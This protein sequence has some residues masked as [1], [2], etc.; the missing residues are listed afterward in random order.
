MKK[1]IVLGLL[2][3]FVGLVGFAFQVFGGPG[4]LIKDGLQATDVL[5]NRLR[6]GIFPQ[7]LISS[8]TI[9]GETLFGT[10]FQNTAA[11]SEVTATM[12]SMEAGVSPAM[13]VFQL[14]K[15]QYPISVKFFSGDKIDGL[16]TSFDTSTDYIYLGGSGVTGAFL[17]ING[18][19]GTSR[20]FLS[21]STGAQIKK[22]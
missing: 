19:G 9:S 21:G 4:D 20:W 11:T 18:T 22:F 14:T 3:A 12:V 10:V 15:T 5:S 6:G 7:N 1:S 13:V 8:E 2:L 17:A 16:P